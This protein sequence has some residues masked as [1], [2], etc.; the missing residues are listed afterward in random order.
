MFET[1]AAVKVKVKVLDKEKELE[2]FSIG[3]GH[4]RYGLL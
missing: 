2:R 1:F 3:D 4:R